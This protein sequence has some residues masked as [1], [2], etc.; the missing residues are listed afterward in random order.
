M[1][2]NRCS[3]S[4]CNRF[5]FKDRVC[6]KHWYAWK[7]P[8]KLDQLVGNVLRTVRVNGRPVVS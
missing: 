2:G 8:W 4:G 5:V 3:E 7:Q 6:T 1:Q